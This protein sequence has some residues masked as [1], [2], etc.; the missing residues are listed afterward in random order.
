MEPFYT[1][2]WLQVSTSSPNGRA[3]RWF[4]L[5][6][7]PGLLMPDAPQISAD[8]VCGKT[9][10]L[11]FMTRRYD[12][13]ASVQLQPILHL[14]EGDENRNGYLSVAEIAEGLSFR[15]IKM[16]DKM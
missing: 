14:K 7:L 4:P 3:V 8:G 2:I 12:I 1:L 10:D 15:R 5:L 9:L 16:L 11:V 6:Q 13:T